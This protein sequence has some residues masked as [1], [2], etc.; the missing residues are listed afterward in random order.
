[1]IAPMS[2]GALCKS[3]KIALA[4]ASRPLRHLATTG[5]GRPDPARCAPP[6]SASS[7][8]A[9]AA[10]SAGTSTSC[11]QADGV[12]IYISQGAKPGLG[13]QLMAK[14]VTEDIAR[15]RGIPAGIDLRSP[16]RHPD[17][18]GADDLVIKVEE[19]REATGWQKPDLGQARRRPRPRRHQ[20]R[21]QGRLRLRRPG[22]PAGLDG[23]GQQRGARVRRHPDAVGDHGGARCARRDRRHRHAGHAHGRRSRTGSTP[24][25]RLR[26]ARTASRSVP[27]AIIAGGC[28]ACLQ[29][30]VGQ[31]VV[32]I[33]TQDPEHEKRYDI[34]V[35]PGTSTATSSPCGGSWRRSSTRTATASVYELSRDDLVALT[36]EAAEITRLPYAPEY[37]EQHA[38]KV[39]PL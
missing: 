4:K 29:C 2:Y 22:R 25:R 26:S 11:A 35:E 39:A 31:C 36:P 38:A 33:A 24:P 16:S 17:V 37:A 27:R 3:T 21:L 1:M 18:L 30:H 32:G 23:R 14:K 19:F 13:G 7:S 10:G 5:R 28:I 8:S 12:E 6:P 34:D 15:L 9:S 20:D